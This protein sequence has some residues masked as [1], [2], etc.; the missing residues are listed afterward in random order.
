MG[1]YLKYLFLV[2]LTVC[3]VDS[4]ASEEKKRAYYY[5]QIVSGNDKLKTVFE[6]EKMK[7]IYDD[8]YK[9]ETAT[10]SD[11]PNKKILACVWTQLDQPQNK[12]LKAEVLSYLNDG[13]NVDEEGSDQ[14]NDNFLNLSKDDSKAVI[15][16]RDFYTRRLEEALY[17]AP[18]N[19]SMFHSQMPDQTDFFK[20]QKTQLGKNIV[21]TLTSYCIDADHVN[22]NGIYLSLIHI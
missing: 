4:I 19:G 22:Y 7:S 11:S 6:N 21:A 2:I 13:K 12:Q 10:S 8:C 18:K 16:L 15:A 3:S 20:L 1:N 17:G 9:Q 14:R 5:Q